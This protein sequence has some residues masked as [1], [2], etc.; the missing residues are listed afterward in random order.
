MALVVI[1][2][3]KL[4]IKDFRWIQEYRKNNDELFF[5]VVDPH[6]TI[7]F[8][9]FNH[10]DEGIIIKH[11]ENTANSFG[12]FDFVLN[13]AEE[14]KDAFNEYWHTFLVPKIGNKEIIEIH[15]KLY[16]GILEKELRKD[17]PFVSHIGVGNS[18]EEMVIK[19]QVLILNSEGV[20]IH[21]KIDYLDICRY[22]EKITT[23]KRIKL[24]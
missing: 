3:P 16:T 2:Y 15:D 8:P 24:R 20:N 7:V 23:L 9:I 13:H 5:D 17:I 18:K 1:A 22:E 11:I 14:N 4:K 10:T 12:G 6:F 19:E 21:G